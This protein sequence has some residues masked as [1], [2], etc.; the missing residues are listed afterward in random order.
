MMALDERQLREYERAPGNHGALGVL[1]LCA[2]V[3]RLQRLVNQLTG[4]LV[5]AG[6]ETASEPASV[7][8]AWCRRPVA[9][10]ESEVGGDGE[11]RYH[12]HCWRQATHE[13][14]P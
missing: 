4:Q 3:R 9:L 7:P 13:G 2:E 11:K 10:S 5:A 1:E 6:V 12:Y 14:E 8:C